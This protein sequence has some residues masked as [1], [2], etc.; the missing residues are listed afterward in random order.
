[1]NTNRAK[2][3]NAWQL[4]LL[5]ALLMTLD[6]LRFIHNLIPPGAATFFTVISRCVAPVFAFLAVEGILHTRNLKKYCLRL[7]ILAGAVWAGN[8]ILN[9]IF[10]SFSATVLEAD[11]KHLY[12]NNNVIFTLAVG[13]LTVASIIRSEKKKTK[14]EYYLL[15]VIGFVVGFLWGEWGSVLLPFMLVTYI[16]RN[17]KLHRYIGYAATE[18]VALAAPFSEPLYFI[19]FPFIFL[20]DGKRGPNTLFNKYFFYIFYPLHLWIIA[21]INFYMTTR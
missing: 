14:I 7:F 17:K 8:T 3:L 16:F 4:K 2:I 19:A 20:Y 6:H 5:M 10:R 12:L 13:V 18:A 11:Q 1:M 21:I 9:Q 15:S